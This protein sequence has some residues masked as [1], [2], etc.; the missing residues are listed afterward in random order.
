M[1]I[2]ALVIFQSLFFGLIGVMGSYYLFTQ[3][4]SWDLLG[5][6]L[7]CGLFSVAVL[8]IN[9]IRD[10]DSDRPP[11]NSPIPVRVGKSRSEVPLG[12]AYRWMDGGGGL[13]RHRYTS[14]VQWIFVLSAP[15]FFLNGRS[16]SQNHLPSS[17]LI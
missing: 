11:E 3:E 10:I 12:I 5:P 13:C 17:I 8:N 9:N 7:S 15:L 14:P 2:W 6:A 1:D 4:F 16:V